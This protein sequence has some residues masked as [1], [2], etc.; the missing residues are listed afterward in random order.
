MKKGLLILSVTCLILFRPGPGLAETRVYV[1]FSVGG[2]AVIGA[3][4]LYW[5]VSY[6]SQVS[7][8]KPQEENPGRLFPA[9]DASETDPFQ[10][11]QPEPQQVPHEEPIRADFTGI[12]DGLRAASWVE[13]PLLVF[14]W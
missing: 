8:R 3:G 2:A 13:V 9:T 4:I 14:R 11:L 6:T 12:P 1:S 10:A 5:S 7:Q